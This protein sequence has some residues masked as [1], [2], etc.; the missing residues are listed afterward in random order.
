MI[1]NVLPRGVNPFVPY[2]SQRLAPRLR[3]SP[4][5]L[6]APGVP[7]GGRR[8][9]RWTARASRPRRQLSWACA[10]SARGPARGAPRPQGQL[11][12]AFLFRHQTSCCGVSGRGAADP[13][14]RRPPGRS[15]GL[16]AL[17]GAGLRE[18]GAC[19]AQRTQEPTRGGGTSGSQNLHQIGTFGT[20]PRA[21]EAPKQGWLLGHMTSSPEPQGGPLSSPEPRERECQ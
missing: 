16:R 3:T 15:W 19:R 2:M 13:Q 18:P 1:D 21:R 7:R 12:P 8:R 11:P 10:G 9:P 14:P 17:A 5:P 20:R 4:G 6:P